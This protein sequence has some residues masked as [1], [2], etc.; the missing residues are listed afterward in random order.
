MFDVYFSPLTSVGSPI[1]AAVA[2]VAA[3]STGT[4]SST[5]VDQDAPSPN[6]DQCF[7]LLIPKP[8]FED[9]SSHVVIPN[10]MH[11]VNQPSEH[12]SKWTKG[13]P[14]DNVISD[15]SRPVSTR[16]QI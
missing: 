10:N 13:H 3:D 5:L 11:S 1:S 8:S 9:S 12:I 14:I 15:P 7:G 6:N 2:Q 4:P 16:H